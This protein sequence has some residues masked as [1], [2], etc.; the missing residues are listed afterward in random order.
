VAQEGRAVVTGRG[1]ARWEAGHPWIYRSDV[2]ERPGSGP[3]AVQVE[4]ERGRVVGMALWS[5]A[6]EIS[7]RMLTR[8]AAA[9][10]GGFWRERI[11]RA[12]R[13]R[14]GVEATGWRL[15]HA[16]ADG[17][18]SLVVDVLGAVVVVQFLSAGLEVYREQ[19]VDA[20]RAEL[21]PLGILGRNDARVRAREGLPLE[22]ALLWGEVPERVEV[23]EAGVRYY[24]APWTGQKT[25]A[26]LDQRENR[27]LAGGLSRG[28]ALDAFCY[29]GSFALHLAGRADRVLALDSSGDALALAREN[30]VL[31]GHGNIETVE[32]N[33]FDHLRALESAG[34]RFDVV[35]LDPPAFAKHR[36]SVPRA[37]RG[38]KELNLRALRLLAPEGH[39]L[40]FSC[41]YHVTGPIFRD[42]L[43]S[44]AADS[45][46]P[47]RWVA[48]LGQASDHPE[49]VQIPET[50]Y[51][52]GAILQA[53]E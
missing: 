46:R 49:I 10:D 37:V 11:G 21:S 34:E 15:V 45:G 18:P 12:R 41:S 6:S 16:E 20:L 13:R 53:V 9:I 7:L 52:K 1:A 33:A 48:W 40:T 35:V 5:P 38:Y 51:L 50:S 25:G 24:A 47:A 43:A 3:G 36:S 30:A 29:H 39:L 44:A 22:T 19:I 17:L 4:D 14:A 2:Q 32:A 26:F 42:M 23:E 27:V 31:N 8:A 28:R